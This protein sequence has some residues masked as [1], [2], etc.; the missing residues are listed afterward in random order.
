MAYD[1]G[2]AERLRQVFSGRPDIEEKK[3]FGGIAF[4]LSGHMCVGINDTM[5]MAR[6]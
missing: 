6:E 4:M 2:L 5:L 3:M 1:E